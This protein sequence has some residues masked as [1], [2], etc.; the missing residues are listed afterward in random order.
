MSY[1]TMQRKDFFPTPG[2]L[3]P[4]LSVSCNSTAHSMVLIRVKARMSE[5]LSLPQARSSFHCMFPPGKLGLCHTASPFSSATPPLWCL[6]F[7]SSPMEFCCFSS[8]NRLYLPKLCCKQYAM[9]I[10]TWF[11]FVWAFGGYLFLR[12]TIETVKILKR[13]FMSFMKVYMLLLDC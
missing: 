2:V 3:T 7:S 11:S 12:L 10:T 4:A 1:K 5:D 9:Q 6:C 8:S 13:N